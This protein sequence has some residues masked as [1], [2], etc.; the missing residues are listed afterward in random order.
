MRGNVRA[1]LGVHPRFADEM[2]PALWDAAVTCGV[3]PVG[4]IAQAAKETRWGNYGGKVRPEFHNT[5]GL[6]NGSSLFPGVDDLDNP[7][8]HARF[9]NWEVGALAHA[10]HLAAYA[11]ARPPF[12]LIVDPRF[13]LVAGK[14]RLE[15]F[16]EL[17]GKWA[18]STT[19]GPELVKIARALQTSSTTGA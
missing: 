17:S 8:A 13:E 7:L 19:Y 3:D 10:Q 11:G 5:C 2:F 9:A 15:N 16:E 4:L 12:G 6:K 14:S 18:P 1:T